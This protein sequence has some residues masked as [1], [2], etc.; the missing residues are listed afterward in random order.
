MLDLLIRPAF[1][2]IHTQ[3]PTAEEQI[4]KKC[5]LT[6]S[7]KEEVSSKIRTDAFQTRNMCKEILHGIWS[8]SPYEATTL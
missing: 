1:L 7:S 4:A 2:I 5:F 3:A 8:L 6:P